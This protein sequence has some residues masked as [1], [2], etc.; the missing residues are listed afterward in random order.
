MTQPPLRS[1]VLRALAA[2]TILIALAGCNYDDNQPGTSTDLTITVTTDE[3]ATPVVMKLECDPPGGNH[4]EPAEA[5]KRI[6]SFNRSNGCEIDRWEK[7]GT[8]VF[9]L[10]LQ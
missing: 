6:K 4:P 1:L 2:A 3:G 7:L 10:P 9:D 8:T 5:C